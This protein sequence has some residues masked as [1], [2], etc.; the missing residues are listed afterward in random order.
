MIT[1]TYKFDC[2]LD[3]CEKAQ[4][5]K[6]CN[7]KNITEAKDSYKSSIDTLV[8]ECGWIVYQNFKDRLALTFCCDE[9]YEL[10]RAKNG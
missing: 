10:Y 1:S 7:T 2:D 4:E 8:N 3:N 5:L 6:F 9:H